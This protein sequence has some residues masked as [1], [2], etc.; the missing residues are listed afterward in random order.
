MP[1][2]LYQTVL[3]DSLMIQWGNKANKDFFHALWKKEQKPQEHERHSN[4]KLFALFED[5][6]ILH[7]LLLQKV[8]DMDLTGYGFY[9][10]VWYLS[11]G[12]Q[13][14]QN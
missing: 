14:M 9:V 11:I 2:E 6:R 13:S 12:Y 7:P 8:Q 10:Y 1:H 3:R 5:Y 4:C